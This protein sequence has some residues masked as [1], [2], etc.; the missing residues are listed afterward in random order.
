[1]QYLLS[2]TGPQW[3]TLVVMATYK[4][5]DSVEARQQVP[6][7]QTA[8]REMSQKN[9][10]HPT[11]N[12]SA[13]QRKLGGLTDTPVSLGCQSGEVLLPVEHDTERR[14]RGVDGEL[15]SQKALR[16]KR[17]NDH[18][19]IALDLLLLEATQADVVHVHIVSP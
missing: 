19:Q 13:G 1:M 9:L 2:R 11:R 3:H 5:V 16:L 6:A 8:E 17:G 18:T 12:C 7:D 15:V 14:R 10:P 4:L